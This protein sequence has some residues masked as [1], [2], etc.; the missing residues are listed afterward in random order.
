MPDPFIG[1]WTL[2]VDKSQFDESHRP[3]AGTMILEIDRDGHYLQTAEGINQKGEKVSERPQRFLA[4]GLDHPVPGS[5]GLSYRA[6]RVAENTIVSE[7]KREDGSIVGGATQVVSADG[8][9]M[10]IDNFGYDSQL[11]PFKMRTVW[12]R[13]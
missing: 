4:D 12:E 13:R 8:G 3:Q 10:T 2:N 1:T 6:T 5:P 9:S 11:R 7:A